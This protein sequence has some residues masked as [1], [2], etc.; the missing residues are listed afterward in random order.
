MP[1]QSPAAPLDLLIAPLLPGG[2]D[3]PFFALAVRLRATVDSRR[4]G[5]RERDGSGAVD[6]I[7][8]G[9]AR[10]AVGQTGRL[11][12]GGGARVT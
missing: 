10:S 11:A 6:G 8:T 9:A 12:A 3:R 4:S 2:L 7:F 1:L 5:A